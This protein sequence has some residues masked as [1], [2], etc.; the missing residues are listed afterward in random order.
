MLKTLHLVL[1]TLKS[2]E[3]VYCALKIRKMDLLGKCSKIARQCSVPTCQ[4]LK[5]QELA[6]MICFSWSG[7]EEE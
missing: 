5:G 7:A 3:M 6:E 1:E 4:N 2:K